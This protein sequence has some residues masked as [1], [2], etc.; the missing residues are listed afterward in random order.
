MAAEVEVW[1]FLRALGSD[2]LHLKQY[3]L[4]YK[5]GIKCLATL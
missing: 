2:I 4:I 5:M 1:S 3:G